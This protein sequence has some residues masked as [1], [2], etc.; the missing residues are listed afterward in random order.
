[1]ENINI[2]N[3][4]M[5]NLSDIEWESICN[6]CGICCLCKIRDASTGLLFMTTLA[7]DSLDLKTKKCTNY[8]NRLKNKNCEKV[9]LKLVDAGRGISMKCAYDNMRFGEPNTKIEIDWSKVKHLKNIGFFKTMSD[10]I[11][12]DSA[13]WFRANHRINHPCVGHAVFGSHR[14]G[15]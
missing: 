11:V 14:A 13:D 5:E 8:E 10:Y 6:A 4:N 9:D 2:K 15:K 12:W 1:M 7:C 3:L